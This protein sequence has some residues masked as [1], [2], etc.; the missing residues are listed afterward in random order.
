MNKKWL[1]SCLSFMVLFLIAACSQVPEDNA[2]IDKET[3]LLTQAGCGGDGQPPCIEV[4]YVEIDL[5]P[6]CPDP[7]HLS[8][9][10]DILT[11]PESL[12]SFTLDV[13]LSSQLAEVMQLN[14]VD[15]RGSVIAEGILQ[16]G[17]RGQM[18]LSL[19]QR[20]LAAGQYALV[21][22]ARGL[23]E[24]AKLQVELRYQF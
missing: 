14:L 11:V 5:C 4:Y 7:Y 23:E 1:M 8:K 6:G 22:A 12:R 9:F 3:H 19:T 18:Q 10:E 13:A 17:A 20:G 24:S 15:V 21:L 2:A 16:E